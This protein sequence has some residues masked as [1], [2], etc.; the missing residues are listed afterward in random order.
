[1]YRNN[2]LLLQSQP[3]GRIMIGKTGSILFAG[4]SLIGILMI[5][6][7]SDSGS[8]VTGSPTGTAS[9]KMAAAVDGPF[10]RIA[11]IATA[12]VSADDMN[13]LTCTLTVS[14]TAVEGEIAGIPAGEERAF[15]VNVYDSNSVLQYTGSAEADVIADSVVEVEITITRIRSDVSINGS[16]I[17]ASSD[18]PVLVA[19][20]SCDSC[21]DNTCYDVTGHG[22]DAISTELVLAS[23]VKG[24]ALSC[25]GSEFD[26][27]V[28]NSEDN[29]NLSKFSIETWFY[30]NTE[31]DEDKA[32]AKLFD[33]QKIK[34]GVRNGF[35]V[36]IDS[37]NK[38]GF[39]IDNG[40][41]TWM[42]CISETIIQAKEWYHIVCT[43]DGAYMKVYINGELDGSLA[44][45]GSYTL[46]HTDAR[47][48][49][50]ARADI[51]VTF[52][53]DGKIDEMKLY[54]FALSEET[55]QETYDEMKPE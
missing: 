51:P 16:I 27:R 38:V 47:I 17:D 54:K 11:D 43:F 8:A 40:G 49:C 52:H 32:Y 53:V 6:T 45:S 10:A 15:I 34:S 19:H 7:C 26:I 42:E 41:S 35:G 5:C 28:N 48:G 31:I 9:V 37:D 13:T 12:V 33:Y 14:E 2:N 55:I 44:F 21:A 18:D 3:K 29:F 36:H 50:A 46:P 39:S 24:E 30:M 4:I 20:W 25:S 22:F 1:M 23:G